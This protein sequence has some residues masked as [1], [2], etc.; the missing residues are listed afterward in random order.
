MN[1]VVVVLVHIGLASGLS[2]S[3]RPQNRKRIATTSTPDFVRIRTTRGNRLQILDLETAVTTLERKHDGA[4]VELHAQ[5]HFGT[6]DYFDYYNSQE[7][8]SRFDRI[9]YELLVDEELITTKDT[10][11]GQYRYLTDDVSIM[12]SPSDRKM[13][14][15]Y[16]LSCQVDVVEYTKPKR[17]HADFTRQEFIAL[18]NKSTSSKNDRKQEQEQLQQPLWA[19]A[20]TSPSWP[21]AEAVS[22]IFRP[23][24]PSASVGQRLFSN[25]FLPGSALATVLRLFFWILVPAPELSV[26]LLDWSSILPRPTGGIVS[27]V[28]MP[29]LESL[30][31]G[32]IRQAQQLVFGQVLVAGQKSSQSANNRHNNDLLIGQR[33]DHALEVLRA[34]LNEDESCRMTALLYGAMHC[35]DLYQK[36]IRQGFTPTQTTWRTAWS[37]RIPKF[38]TSSRQ[39]S[40]SRSRSSSTMGSSGDNFA[41]S[42]N[43]LAVGLVV[44][45]FYLAV[46]GFDWISTLHDIE[47]LMRSGSFFDAA[48]EELLYL[49]RHVALYLSLV[50]FVVQW[51]SSG[52][53]ED[54]QGGGSANSLF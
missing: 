36:L 48:L 38:G 5:I 28:A 49:V 52:V 11:M 16:G 19:L 22:A 32:N 6:H 41:S 39:S 21:G 45:P 35:P 14:R 44:V 10:Q 17:V 43:A 2:I 31:T 20:S 42:P 34:S 15:Q 24:T 50:K 25:L 7:F 53:G 3:K 30:L 29:V 18:A 4:K 51:D 26:M 13:A 8:S 9:L 33:N 37:V 40:T 46:G 54:N 23:S 12:A 1:Y 27:P 47:V